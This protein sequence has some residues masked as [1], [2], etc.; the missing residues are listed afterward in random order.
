MIVIIDYV[1]RNYNYYN[2]NTYSGGGRRE[3]AYLHESDP[4]PLERSDRAQDDEHGKD[5]DDGHKYNGDG[6]PFV[7]LNDVGDK[8]GGFHPSG[9][10][11]NN[12]AVARDD[13][14]I[15]ARRM[16]LDDYAEEEAVTE[17]NVTVR[18]EP[19]HEDQDDIKEIVDTDDSSSIDATVVE[20][21]ANDYINNTEVF[22]ILSQK[23]DS[24]LEKRNAA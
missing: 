7:S 13:L 14:K 4:V 21:D 5:K 1:D 11:I 9:N 19:L 24:V 6:V 22:R 3:Y 12:K 18:L 23:I 2:F 16:D 8:S 20:L 15:S 10:S 17:E